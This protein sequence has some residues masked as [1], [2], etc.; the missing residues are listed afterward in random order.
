M[1]QAA[2]KAILEDILSVPPGMLKKSD[3]RDTLEE[4]SSLAD[5]EILSVI[6]SEFGIEADSSLL[7]YESVGELL[8]ILERKGALSSSAG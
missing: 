1:T 4:W 5:V 7:Y 3:T 2:F 6:S 8:E